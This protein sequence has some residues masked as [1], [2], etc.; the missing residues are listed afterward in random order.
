[1]NPKPQSGEGFFAFHTVA[2]ILQSPI[3][4]ANLL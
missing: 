1:M 2:N 3:T 4:L